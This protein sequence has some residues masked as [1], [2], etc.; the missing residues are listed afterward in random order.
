MI[1]C[2]LGVGLLACV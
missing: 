1:M 2:V